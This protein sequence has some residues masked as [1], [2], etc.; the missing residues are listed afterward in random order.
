VADGLVQWTTTRPLIADRLGPK[1]V[2]VAD[3]HLPQLLEVL[4]QLGV[5]VDVG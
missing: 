3:E 2:S 5:M 4:R 1:A